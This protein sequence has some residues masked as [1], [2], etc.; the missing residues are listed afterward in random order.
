MRKNTKIITYYLPQY[1]ETKENNNWW[2][3]G[4]TEWVNVKNAKPLFKNHDQPK[5]PYNANYYCLLD[6]NTLKWQAA[7]ASKNGIYGFAFYHYWFKGRLLLERPIDI[8]HTNKDINIKFMLFWA[9]HTWYKSKEGKKEILIKQSYGQLEDW[10][11]HYLY[12]RNFFTD[13]RYIKDDNMPVIG[14]YMPQDII[15]KDKMY[16]KWNQW[17]IADGYNGIKIIE[18]LNHKS[19]ILNFKRSC[20]NNQYKIA[21]VLR[22]PNLAK[23]I[24]LRRPDI[25]LKKVIQKPTKPFIYSYKKIMENEKKTALQYAKENNIY[26]GINTNWDNTPRHGIYG[27]VF[28][29]FDV[30]KFKEIFF[31]MYKISCLNKKE[32]IFINA[33]N[34]WA[35]GMYLEPDNIYGNALLEAIN[36]IRKMEF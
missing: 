23:E 20:V 13:E 33:W 14:I 11:K 6:E 30:N 4:F 26:L 21:G 24:I 36:E 10:R 1:Y 7:L 18:S 25:K 12:F 22:E 31:N 15:E 8:V 5:K 3:N 34:E 17:A 32:Y 35:E 27:E 9:N 19:E 16:A 29:N 28:Q 2:G